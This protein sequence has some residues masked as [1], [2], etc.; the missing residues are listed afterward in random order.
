MSKNLCSNGRPKRRILNYVQIF[1]QVDGPPQFSEAK[2]LNAWRNMSYD[3][4]PSSSLDGLNQFLC[5]PSKLAE[6]II[7]YLTGWDVIN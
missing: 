5:Q 4:D 1:C 7:F 6:R 3:P 2:C